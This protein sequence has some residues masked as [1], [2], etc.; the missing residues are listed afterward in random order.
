MQAATTHHVTNIGPNRVALLEVEG[1]GTHLVTARRD[2]PGS[3]WVV[4]VDGQPDVEAI[5]IQ[6]VVD[7]VIPDHHMMSV[8]GTLKHEGYAIWVPHT[9][10]QLDGPESFDKWHAS[11]GRPALT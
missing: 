11:V 10:R 4:S 5:D 8:H 3:P 6:H 7:R 1:D 2:G 9:V